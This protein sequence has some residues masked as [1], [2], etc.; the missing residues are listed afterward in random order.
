M[1][2]IKLAEIIR[3]NNCDNDINIEIIPD[4]HNSYDYNLWNKY[5]ECIDYDNIMKKRN[6][7]WIDNHKYVL[8][9]TSGE[10]MKIHT[11]KINLTN[12]INCKIKYH[13][14]KI[15]GSYSTDQQIPM[16]KLFM[17]VFIARKYVKYSSH[18]DGF[19][20]FH[21]K[22]YNKITNTYDKCVNIVVNDKILVDSDNKPIIIDSDILIDHLLLKAFIKLSNIMRIS[23]KD[24]NI[25]SLINI[26][27]F[28]ND[29]KSDNITNIPNI[30]NITKLSNYKIN[31][32]KSLITSIPDI[33]FNVNKILDECCD[34]NPIELAKQSA[35]I[36][37][38]IM[39]II[40]D[41]DTRPYNKYASLFYDLFKMGMI[42]SVV[43]ENTYFNIIINVSSDQ[44]GSMI[45]K[46]YNIFTGGIVDIKFETILY[47]LNQICI[48][49]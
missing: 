29:D 36:A 26:C 18:N 3:K 9:Y 15:N 22:L 10:Y 17:C 47:Q 41:N 31:I 20:V 40:M 34:D 7:R 5:V 19:I 30:T 1:I 25:N 27:R 24:I 21:F 16:I 38:N 2:P 4:I 44:Y 49:C 11:E 35:W 32:N 33:E 37:E 6:N 42:N 45:I 12:D 14:S 28:G 13:F 23:I 43:V 8:E 39:S 48:V 46:F